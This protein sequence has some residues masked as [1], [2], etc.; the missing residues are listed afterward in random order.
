MASDD[1]GP[2]GPDLSK[3]VSAGDLP[4]GGM[5]AGHIG[6]DEIL[7]VRQNGTLFALSAHCTHYH[8][9]LADGLLVGETVRCPWHH[10]R[11]NLADRRSDRSAGAQPADLLA[12][13]RA[14]RQGLRQKQK[15]PSPRR[16]QP[17]RQT[18]TLSSSVAALPDLP[19]RRCCAAAA[20]PDSITML[21]NDDAAPV[22]RP[23]LSKDYLAGSAPEDWVPLRG[24]DWYAE[25]KIDLKLKTEVASLDAKSKEL[26]LGERQQDEVRQ[27]AAGDRRRAGQA[28]HSGRRSAARPH[29]ALARRL[30]RDHRAGEDRQARG[31]HRREL[32]RAGGRRR[33]ARA[34]DRSP[35][36]RAGEAPAGTGVR[37]AAGRLHP[38]AARRARRHIPSR[39]HCHAQSTANA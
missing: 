2:T 21:S 13:R 30:P 17:D 14:G 36:R 8:G 15:E 27:T 11:F 37:T 1:K 19:P 35:C 28:R 6:D 24:D 22:D 34:R 12:G 39:G 26:T 31:R 23:N 32:H 16:R 33:A 29:V 5:L 18:S 3:G 9:P 4:D 7:L 25:N 10:A 20:S 38:R